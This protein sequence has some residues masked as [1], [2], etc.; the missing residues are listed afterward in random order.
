MIS[1]GPSKRFTTNDVSETAGRCL[2][3]TGAGE[4]LSLGLKPGTTI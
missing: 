4:L 2:L 3:R 1:S